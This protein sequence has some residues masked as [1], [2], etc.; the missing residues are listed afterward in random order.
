MIRF[1]SEIKHNR[2]EVWNDSTE[3]GP[4]SSSPPSQKQIKILQAHPTVE[5]GL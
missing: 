4:Q 2:A 3:C 5:K 1:H